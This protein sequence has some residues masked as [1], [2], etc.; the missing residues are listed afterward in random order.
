MELWRGFHTSFVATS[1]GRRREVFDGRAVAAYY[2]RHG[3][4]WQDSLAVA[5]WITQV[6]LLAAQRAGVPLGAAAQA[7]QYVRIVRLVRFASVLRTLGRLAVSGGGGGPL[8]P[9]PRIRP[10][11]A[12]A[13]NV[14]YSGVVVINFFACLW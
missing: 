6:C 4:L 9:L 1:G 12:H 11:V 2:A 10:A 5:V 7:F 3:S 13:L 14:A 8:L